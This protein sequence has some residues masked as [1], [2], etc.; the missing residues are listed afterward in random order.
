MKNQQE[1]S[2]KMS[3]LER[4][5]NL[6]VFFVVA[7]TILLC[8]MKVLVTANWFKNQTWDNQ[9]LILEY[10]ESFISMLSFFTYFLLYAYLL[11]ISVQVTLEVV[12]VVEA[13]FIDC[14]GY[15]YSFEQEQYVWCKTSSLVEELG[16]INYLFTDKTGTLTK[17]VMEF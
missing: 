13:R 12:K 2:V 9:F 8:A 16:Q 4:Q 5:I 1:S 11:P 15:M 10:D 14:D 7:V 6:L 3:H 17:N